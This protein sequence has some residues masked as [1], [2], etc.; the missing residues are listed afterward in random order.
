MELL[1]RRADGT[2]VVSLNGLPYHVLLDDPLYAEVA[3]AAVGVT[4]PPEP[5]PPADV[6]LPQPPQPTRAELMAQ[7]LRIQ[8]QIE[9]LPAV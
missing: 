8:A 5:G 4:L 9:A 7:L 1:H 3:A 2:F 6:V